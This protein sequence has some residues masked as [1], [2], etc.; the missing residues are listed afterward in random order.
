VRRYRRHRPYFRRRRR[1]HGYRK[2]FNR[3]RRFRKPRL[4]HFRFERT[5]CAQYRNQDLHQP[6]CAAGWWTD[7]FSLTLRQLLQSNRAVG[8][9]DWV[10]PFQEFCIKKVVVQWTPV[11]EPNYSLENL[12]GHTATDLLGEDRQKKFGPTPDETQKPPIYP[13]LKTEPPLENRSSMKH[14]NFRFPVKR[15]FRP[16]PALP[17]DC[18][19]QEDP[20]V[21][22]RWFSRNNK[23]LTI[24][25]NMDTEWDGIS[26]DFKQPCLGP[27]VLNI[28][29]TAYVAFREFNYWRGFSI[30]TQTDCKPCYHPQGQCD[31]LTCNVQKLNLGR[32][33][34]R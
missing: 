2:R 29:V 18:K 1:Y 33:E 13:G 30:C 31:D 28:R 14:A 22:G 12:P 6:F 19:P 15:I 10:P 4:F 5:W 16:V 3:R 7:R 11:A 27:T 17:A 25:L 26:W 8:Q 23:W 21:C 9:T 34:S 24:R 20:S 32:G